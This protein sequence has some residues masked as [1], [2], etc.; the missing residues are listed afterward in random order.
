MPNFDRHRPLP[1]YFITD[2][3]PEATSDAGIRRSLDQLA[4]LGFGGGVVF[5]KPPGG[6]TQEEYLGP[7]WFD[8]LRRFGEYARKKHL[9]FLINDGFNFPPGSAGGRIKEPAQRYLVLDE[10]GEV[11]ERVADWGAPAFEE[12]ESSRRFIELVYETHR[13]EL[14]DL[15]NEPYFGFFSDADCRRVPHGRFDALGQ[16]TYYPWSRHF[17]EIFRERYGYDLK[18]RLKAVM[19]RHDSEAAADYWQLAGELYQN[20][21]RRNFEWCRQHGL[22]YYFHSSDAGPLH[23]DWYPRSS[24][25][26]E[27]DYFY[28]A[29][30]ATLPGTDHEMPDLDSCGACRSEALTIPHWYWGS[31]APEPGKGERHRLVRGDTR[32][33]FASSA[34]FLYRKPG[35]MCELFAGTS[36]GCSPAILR[37]IAAWQIMQGVTFLV[38]HAYHHRLCGLTKFFAPPSFAP[39]HP[40]SPAQRMVNDRFAE[41]CAVASEGELLAPVAVLAPTAGMWRD[42]IDADRFNM[43]C[44][45]MNRRPHGYVIA[46]PEMVFSGQRR[47]EVV[48][49]CGLELD[50]AFFREAEQR[51][52]RILE[53][54]E[55]GSLPDPPE[56][57]WRGTGRPH[58]MR[59]RSEAGDILLLANIEDDLRIHG[60]LQWL[61]STYPVELEPGDIA[62]WKPGKNSFAAPAA[63]C[64]RETL[65]DRVEVEW[66]APNLIPLFRWERSDGEAAGVDSD[67]PVLNF[68]YR[69][70]EEVD[71]PVLLVPAAVAAG[72]AEVSWDGKRLESRA[73]GR[74]FDDDYLEYQLPNG[75]AAGPHEIRIVRLEPAAMAPEHLWYLRGDFDV[76]IGVAGPPSG[77][78]W[79]RFLYEVRIPRYAEITL[80]RR[81]RRLSTRIGWAEQG[82]PFYSGGAV[83]RCEVELSAPATLVI[84]AIGGVAALAVDGAEPELRCWSPWRWRL[85][86]GAA[87][88]RLTVGNTL[89]NQLDG[90]R[91]AS[92]ILS[93]WHLEFR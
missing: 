90:R 49:N 36:W 8:F 73:A 46:P 32:A 76:D 39:H 29:Q 40:W 22:E 67:A 89:A 35:A 13:R 15:I 28:Q 78:G 52:V 82:Q 92:G 3:G 87:R 7:A 6:F 91:A 74:V 26:T 11:A 42:R 70:R 37:D 85:P 2:A 93:G 61:G 54:E 68:V 24:I 66:P 65:P 63:E 19:L 47:F 55:A 53:A 71:A 75:G 30:F 31:R 43:V 25:F 88:L 16:R 83:Y 34:A 64:L 9:R 79:I 59:R 69:C 21:F 14:R 48:I 5:N 1:F 10:A 58:F 62:Y 17:A 27:G 77:N 84:P 20:W 12:E 4:E 72:I 38:P 57:A 51:Q 45:A 60:E 56:C 81:R 18:P 41:W 23:Q 44:E 86:A 33:K 80:S 50:E